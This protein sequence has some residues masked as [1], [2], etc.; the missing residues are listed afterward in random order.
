MDPLSGRGVVED[1]LHA[2]A[3]AVA[4][5]QD[6]RRVPPRASVHDD[7]CRGEASHD[8]I[9]DLLIVGGQPLGPFG[10]PFDQLSV[11]SG[12]EGGLVGGVDAMAGQADPG[13]GGT[14]LGTPQPYGVV[15]LNGIGH[16]LSAGEGDPV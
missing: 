11:D 16:G 12:G 13:P 9:G 1:L 6:L 10:R 14:G 5:A 15:D 7:A 2:A 8:G 4:G 3:H